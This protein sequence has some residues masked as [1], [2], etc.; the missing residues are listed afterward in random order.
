[1]ENI[2]V[3]LRVRPLNLKESL[4]QDKNYWQISEKSSNISL[5]SRNVPDFSQYK[6][7]PSKNVYSFSFDQC[8]SEESNNHL[9]YEKCVRK[10]V[11]SSLI[12]IN[13]TV[14]MYGQTGAGKT[15]TMLGPK[16]ENHNE[17]Y[18]ECSNYSEK[19]SVCE[20]IRENSGI[21]LLALNDFFE[22]I[23][24]VRKFREIFIILLKFL[25]NFYNFFI[26]FY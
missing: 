24:K 11:E 8:F 9:I 14:F 18:G 1:M 22:L 21:L 25:L 13:G 6:R 16:N 17:N 26:N 4:N 3:S 12:G 15:Y 7:G 2:Q 23:E 10:L 5:F 20:D 19:I